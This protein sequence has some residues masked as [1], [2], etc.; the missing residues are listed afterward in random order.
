MHQS[1]LLINDLQKKLNAAINNI[2]GSSKDGKKAEKQLD[3]PDI[4]VDNTLCSKCAGINDLIAKNE[5]IDRLK[6]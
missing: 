1:Q 6:R 5:E 2:A 4:Q 3:M